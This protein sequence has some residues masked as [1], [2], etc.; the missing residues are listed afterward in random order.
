MTQKFVANESTRS[1]LLDQAFDLVQRV[2][3]GT[4][5]GKKALHRLRWIIEDKDIIRTW[6]VEEDDDYCML[7]LE[8][9]IEENIRIGCH[10]MLGF[11]EKE[12]RQSMFNIPQLGV[13]RRYSDPVIIDP[14]L[15][16]GSLCRVHNVE[17]WGSVSSAHDHVFA[18]RESSPKV[19]YVLWVVPTHTE[20]EGISG[21]E[22]IQ[23]ANSGS[24]R[25]LSVREMLEYVFHFSNQLPDPRATSVRRPM[26]I[27]SGLSAV[28]YMQALKKEELNGAVRA[29]NLQV[30]SGDFGDFVHLSFDLLETRNSLMPYW[31][32]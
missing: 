16:L 8:Y 7:L 10:R 4:L 21:R 1:Q 17:G 23:N 18:D 25:L 28:A 13:T 15:H 5:D 22:F 24:A 29:V 32:G 6:R 14:R 12:Y 20:W 19:P 27:L 30:R 3:E 26:R 31:Q 9:Q 11:G 2:K